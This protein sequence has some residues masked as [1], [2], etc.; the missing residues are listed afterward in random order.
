MKRLAAAGLTIA[1]AVAASA[2][3]LAADLPQP[4]EPYT[5]NEPVPAERFDWSGFY[6]G[7]HLGWNWSD[8]QTNNA[9]TGRF[10]TRDNGVTGGVHAGYNY[11]L[12]PEFLLGAEADFSL[13]DI[14][15]SRT[16]AG[17]NYKTSSDWNG[18]LR[19]RAGWAFDRFLVFGTGGMAIA[20]IDAAANGVSKDSVRV[21]WTAGAGIE[22]AVTQN[23]TAR[24][25]YQYQ[26]YGSDKFAIGGQTYKTDLDNNQVRFGMSYKF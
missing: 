11:M 1:A 16:V 14:E 25:E 5:Y 13:S 23:I 3:A 15:K 4:A 20:D 19:A 21:G 22:G 24:V 17:V 9:V 2:P 6:F 7:G 12:T 18:T 8:F 26:N 10:N